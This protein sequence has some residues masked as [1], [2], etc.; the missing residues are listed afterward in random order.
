MQATETVTGTEVTAL[1]AS[2]VAT[3]D[4]SVRW[5]S[6]YL[7]LLDQSLDPTTFTNGLGSTSRP[8]AETGIDTN[9]RNGQ[10]VNL[11]YAHPKTGHAYTLD[12]EWDADFNGTSGTVFCGPGGRY[13]PPWHCSFTMP[14]TVPLAPPVGPPPV[15]APAS[16]SVTLATPGGTC[17]A[18]LTVAAANATMLSFTGSAPAP[19]C[20]VTGNTYAYADRREA[21]EIGKGTGQYGGTPTTG[22]SLAVPGATYT[23]TY[24]LSEQVLPAQL[25]SLPPECASA[26]AFGDSMARCELTASVVFP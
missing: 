24:Y 22:Q 5:Q 10:P 19:G 17:Q 3:C 25:A 18:T 26:D 9:L 12:W 20:T 2:A 14:V 6:S 13:S 1:Q 21:V 8:V 16:H 4:G 15:V 11:M 23:V 7:G